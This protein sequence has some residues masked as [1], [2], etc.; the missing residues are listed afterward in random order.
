MQFDHS[1][2]GPDPSGMGEGNRAERRRCAGCVG[3]NTR[4]PLLAWAR[5]SILYKFVLE[6]LERDSYNVYE[7]IN[8]INVSLSRESACA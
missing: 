5:I 6:H 8:N 7:S 1:I 3:V 2:Y 4:R